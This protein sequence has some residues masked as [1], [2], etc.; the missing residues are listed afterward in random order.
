[1]KPETVLVLSFVPAVALFLLGFSSHDAGAFE[2]VRCGREV[3]Y[4]R[5]HA[6]LT[7]DY[8]KGYVEVGFEFDVSVQQAAATLDRL[9]AHWEIDYPYHRYAWVCTRPGEEREWE[10]RLRNTEGVQFAHQEGVNPL[11]IIGD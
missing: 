1:V 7:D 3:Q 11:E 5:T 8:N 2:R 10:E 4:H 9:G 6:K